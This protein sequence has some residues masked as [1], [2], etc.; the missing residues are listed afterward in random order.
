[1][2]LL[3]ELLKSTVTIPLRIPVVDSVGVFEHSLLAGREADRDEGGCEHGG[4][5][6]HGVT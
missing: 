6:L 1:V 2:L 3:D 5:A 4:T